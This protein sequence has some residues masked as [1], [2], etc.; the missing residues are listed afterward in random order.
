VFANSLLDRDLPPL[1]DPTS[2][3]SSA[4]FISHGQ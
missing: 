4:Q 2:H 3:G 1:A